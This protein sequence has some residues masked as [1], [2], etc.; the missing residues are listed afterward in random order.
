MQEHST[1]SGTATT[2]VGSILALLATHRGAFGQERVYRR[3]VALVFAELFVFARHTVTQSLWALGV[4]GEDWSAWYRLFSRPRFEE[5]EL[6]HYLFGETLQEVKA[7]ELYVVGVDATQ[8]PRTSM[9]MPGTS[10]LRAL[11]TASGATLLAGG[12]AATDG[13]RLHPCHPLAFSA[14]LS[15]QSD[16]R[17]RGRHEGMGSSHHFCQMGT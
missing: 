14:R 7:E 4:M 16:S 1:K 15:C 9:K 6:A 10:W 17:Q 5:A 12:M 2:L 8:V 13:A 3:V 11:R